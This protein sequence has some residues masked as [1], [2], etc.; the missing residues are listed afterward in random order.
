[1]ESKKEH[2]RDRQP[3]LVEKLSKHFMEEYGITDEDVRKRGFYS[4]DYVTMRP[5]VKP[6]GLRKKSPSHLA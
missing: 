5:F 2:G 6:S 3:T 1:M 4:F